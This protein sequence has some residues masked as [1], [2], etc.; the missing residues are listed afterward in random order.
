M[1]DFAANVSLLFR[2]VPLLERFAAARAAGFT[3]VELQSPYAEKPDDLAHAAHDSGTNVVLMNVPTTS[4][5]PLGIACRPE[6]SALFRSQLGMAAEYAQAL[7]V[8]HVNVLAG[9]VDSPAQMSQCRDALIDNLHFAS[10]VLGRI[11]VGV[12]IEPLNPRDAP[13]YFANSFSLARSIVDSCAG[14][15]GLQF[16]VYHAARMGL[17][18]TCALTDALP[19]VRHLQFADSPGRHEPGTG[20]VRFEPIWRL[21]RDS[22]YPGFV[23]AEY[24]PSSSLHWLSEWRARFC[25]E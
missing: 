9:Q 25:S 1:F 16:E 2:E 5:R 10:D 13:G 17:D 8:R 7:A 21:L 22:S 12:L 3:A 15:V 23:G 6:L 19:A 4:V 11:A 20:T 18:P 14:R 24:V